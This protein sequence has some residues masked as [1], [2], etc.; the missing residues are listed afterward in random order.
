MALASLS[1][2]QIID[3]LDSG[4]HWVGSTIT[5]AFPVAATNLFWTDEGGSFRP[6]GAT[7]QAYAEVALASW[8][9]LIAPSF[10]EVSGSASDIEFGLTLN[11]DYAHAYFPSYGSVWFRAGDAS[12]ADP[13]VGSYGYMTYVHEVGHALGL[14]HMGDYNGYSP[15]PTSYQDSTVLSVMSYFGPSY[16]S[17]SAGTGQVAWADWVGADGQHYRP[18]TPML[19]DVL[20][21]QSMYGADRTTRTGDTTYGFGSNVTGAMAEILDFTRNAHPVLTIYDA[22]GNDTLNLSGWSSGSTVDIAPGAYSSCND[23][24]NNIAIAYSADI[25]NVVCGDGSDSISGNTLD[26]RSG[27]DILIG[28]GGRDILSGAAGHDVFRFD[29]ISDT[30]ANARKADTI[31]DFAIGEDILDLS[32]IDANLLTAGNDAFDATFVAAG[33]AF[34][35]PGQLQFAAGILYGNVD[36]DAKPEFAINVGQIALSHSDLAL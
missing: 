32:R 20:A 5:Y 18:Q 11:A 21:I 23:M 28:A 3:Q 19:D 8:D 24:T 25:E 12:L 7:Q 15:E 33:T 26:G 36:A 6:L 14:D 35:A 10:A 34:Y 29:A 1:T 4:Y 17:W 2:Q 31:L 16:G 22:G 13:E 27:D 9:E 30:S